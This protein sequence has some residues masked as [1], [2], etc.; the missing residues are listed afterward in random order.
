MASLPNSRKVSTSENYEQET[1]SANELQREQ[2]SEI[3]PDNTRMEGG[4]QDVMTRSERVSNP[5]YLNIEHMS[6]DDKAI[7]TDNRSPSPVSPETVSASGSTHQKPHKDLILTVSQGSHVSVPIDG[8]QRS[9]VRVKSITTQ[10][11][12]VIRNISMNNSV[13]YNIASAYEKHSSSFSGYNNVFRSGS[14]K[15]GERHK[16]SLRRDGQVRRASRHERM[17]SDR[18]L[19]TS[20]EDKVNPL[21]LLHQVSTDSCTSVTSNTQLVANPYNVFNHKINSAL[22]CPCFFFFC[23][24]CCL[25]ATRFMNRSDV[26]FNEGQYNKARTYARISTAFFVVGIL[27]SIGILSAIFTLIITFTV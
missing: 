13:K 24:C 21:K 4:D 17:N 22:W 19:S 27:L 11:G 5:D 8:E 18:S 2:P 20:S 3:Q 10:G 12:R 1:Q 14:V 25:P 6:I 16:P 7:L 9:I 15:Q 26:L 23:F